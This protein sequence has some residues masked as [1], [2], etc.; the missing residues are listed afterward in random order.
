MESA[1]DSSFADLLVNRLWRGRAWILLYTALF[2][3]AATLVAFL[4]APTYRAASVVVSAS[5]E[6]N[7]MGSLSASLGQ[8]GSL[9]ALAGISVGSPDSETE[10]ALAVMRSRD[11]TERFIFDKDLMPKLFARKWDQARKRWKVGP[12]RQPTPADAYKYFDREVRTLA[13][14]KKT[15]LIVLQIDWKDRNEAAAWSN[16]LLSRIN[17]EMRTRAIAKADAS[18]GYLQAELNHT[19]DIGTREAVNRIIEAQV[20]QRMLASV[21]QEYAFRVID[22]ALPPDAKDSVWPVKS[23]LALLGALVGALV[24]CVVAFFAATD[25]KPAPPPKF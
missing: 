6:R 25:C 1:I 15:G 12:A 8:L 11:F 23:M 13:R 18:I 21:T 16:E 2:A 22:R 10:E 4:M 5:A 20:K 24:G 14:D 19:S 3:A 17:A 7:S 9:A